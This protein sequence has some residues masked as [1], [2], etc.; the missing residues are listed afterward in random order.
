MPWFFNTKNIVGGF[1]FFL[2]IQWQ[3]DKNAERIL[4]QRERVSLLCSTSLLPHTGNQ[5]QIPSTRAIWI[6]SSLFSSVLTLHLF[7]LSQTKGLNS[8]TCW[9][10]KISLCAE[11]PMSHHINWLIKKDLVWTRSSSCLDN[12]RFPQISRTGP[13]SPILQGFPGKWN[14][15][16]FLCC[17]V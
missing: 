1:L 10:G 11:A 3:R 13:H 5:Q 4:L 9:V 14:K 17:P 12:H 6:I 15:E 8:K 2:Q 7:L 16:F